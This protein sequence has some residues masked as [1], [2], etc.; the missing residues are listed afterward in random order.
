[1]SP[2]VIVPP[3]AELNSTVAPPLSHEAE[4]EL[5]VHVPVNSQGAL[6]KLKYPAAL[7]VTFE[8]TVL[9]PEAPAVIPPATAAS[10]VIT[11]TKVARASAAPELT[12]SVPA[13]V[14][15]L[16]SVTVPAAEIV[17]LL[18]ALSPDRS[19]IEVPVP[20]IVT[21]LDP[22]VNSE[23]APLLFQLPE[24]VQS[25]VVRVRTPLD[26]P[27]MVKLVIETVLAF[28]VRIPPLPTLIAPVVSPKSEVAS[29]VVDEASEIVSVVPQR[30]A[31]VLMVKVCGVPADDENSALLNSASAK[32]A[33]AKVIVPPV[34]FVK[35]TVPVPASHTVPSVDALVQVPVIVQD[36]LPKSIAD[37]ALEILTFPVIETVPDVEVRSPPDIVR[38]PNE[39]VKAFV[40]LANVPPES[41]N[42]VADSWL[43]SVRVPPETTTVAK[44][45]LAPIVRLPFPLNVTDEL[46]A[47]KV[48]AEDVSQKP[49]DM[50]IVAEAKVIVAAPLEVRL[51]APNV[52]VPALVAVNVPD[53]VKLAANVV[54]IPELTVKLFA[55]SSMLTVPPDAAIT[56]VEIPTV[57]VPVDV[58]MEVT[59]IVLAL[60][61]R[62]PPVV[63][64]RVVAVTARFPTEVSSAVVEE[65]SLTLIV[66]ARSPRVDIVKT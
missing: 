63:T 30:S 22:C 45:W 35:V 46:V 64:L 27:V 2:N 34:P 7:T 11:T 59:V 62:I 20:L 43:S 61:V 17:K 24:R 32:F 40:P 16:A 29:S 58:S 4:V 8:L 53:Q 25:P 47:V 36:S 12:V 41:V 1:V 38:S 44:V 56:T 39:T 3:V 28:A 37:D 31:R 60:A 33:P 57:Y 65:P 19:V 5:F 23:P 26:P 18:K 51:L 55:V 15:S 49:V 54:L 66:V 13:T 21:V 6:P 42:T 10:V 50:V 52:S 9:L 48:V 14:I